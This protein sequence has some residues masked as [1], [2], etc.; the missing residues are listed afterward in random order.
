MYFLFEYLTF[1]LLNNK[2]QLNGTVVW[3]ILDSNLFYIIYIIAINYVK[4][5]I[6]VI[7]SSAVVRTSKS[8][9]ISADA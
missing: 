6:I 8:S 7:I 3:P 4:L 9:A 1:E 2:I 5:F